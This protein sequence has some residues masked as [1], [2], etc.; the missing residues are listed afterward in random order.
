MKRA[1]WVTLVLGLVMLAGGQAFGTAGSAGDPQDD[2]VDQQGGTVACNAIDF[3]TLS[4]D[5]SSSTIT[6][7][8]KMW[9]GFDRADV[10]LITWALDFDGDGAPE[11]CLDV[12]DNGTALVGEFSDCG[13]TSS[14]YGSASVSH[15]N[16][17]DT[18]TVSFPRSKLTDLGMPSGEDGYDYIVFGAANGNSY[19]YDTAPNGNNEEYTHTLSP[20]STPTPSP[21]SGTESRGETNDSTVTRGQKITISGGG[22]Q[23]NKS[24][25]ITFTSTPVSLGTTTSNSSGR[26]S[27]LVTIPSDATAGSHTITV[28]GPGAAGGTH[29]SVIGVTVLAS[30]LPATGGEPARD[31]RAALFL[32]AAGL[33]LVGAEVRALRP[34]GLFWETR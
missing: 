2:C 20:T 8:A 10:D 1:V 18:L 7:T 13:Q 26:Y 12:F 31:F 6:Y 22:F 23:A 33:L 5:D 25:S 3:K 28:S 27:A 4:H 32:L 14:S 29:N 15:T 11:R 21:G 17:S 24:L 19:I 34:R 30:S 9:A 16:D